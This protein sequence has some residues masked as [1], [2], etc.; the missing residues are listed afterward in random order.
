MYKERIKTTAAW[1]RF[2][3]VLQEKL[4]WFLLYGLW[5]MVLMIGVVFAVL[6]LVLVTCC[7]AGILLVI[8]YIGTVLM[9]PVYVA[10][11]ALSLE[12]L[13]QFS[14]GFRLFPEPQPA[15]A[16]APPGGGAPPPPPEPPAATFEPDV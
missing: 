2:G 15:L 6:L 7:V 16:A 3:P 13:A 4:G 14:D 12:F 11:R 9:L 10:L 8:P 1:R 5:L